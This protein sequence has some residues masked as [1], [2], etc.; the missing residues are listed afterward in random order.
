MYTRG[1]SQVDVCLDLALSRDNKSYAT[2][3]CHNRGVQFVLTFLFS[4][5]YIK[6][7]KKTT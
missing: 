1:R 4:F 7:L 2:D 6:L 5:F 3:T